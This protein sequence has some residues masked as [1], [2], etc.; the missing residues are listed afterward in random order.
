MSCQ[1]MIK[2][3]DDGSGQEDREENDVDMITEQK[4]GATSLK[5]VHGS[6]QFKVLQFN[7]RSSADICLNKTAL[8]LYFWLMFAFCFH[9]EYEQCCLVLQKHDDP[10]YPGAHPHKCTVLLLLMSYILRYN[11]TRVAFQGIQNKSLKNIQHLM[12]WHCSR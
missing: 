11:W 10:A 12:N 2:E 6:N 8:S 4:R 1:D 9:Y 5:P 3:K 7:H